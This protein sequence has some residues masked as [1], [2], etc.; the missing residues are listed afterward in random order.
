MLAMS[1]SEMK[2]DRTSQRSGG[3]GDRWG[4]AL[5]KSDGPDKQVATDYEKDC[6]ACHIPARSTEWVYVQG[7]PVLTSK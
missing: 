4:W 6:L 3:W 5:F 2:N 7:F 1:S